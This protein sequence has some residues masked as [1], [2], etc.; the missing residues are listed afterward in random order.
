MFRRKRKASDFSSEM[1]A[2][3]QLETD[4]LRF[5]QRDTSS[6]ALLRV[7]PLALLG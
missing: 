2:H 4:R 7:R 3:I 1:E 6:R 5:R